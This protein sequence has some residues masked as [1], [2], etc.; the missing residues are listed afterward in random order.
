M[1]Y[2]RINGPLLE[3]IRNWLTQRTQKV[4]LNGEASK[5]VKVISGV[6]QGTV[7]GLLMFLLYVNDI[8]DNTS[9]SIRMFADDCV[10]YRI[11]QTPSDHHYLQNDL[12]A[13]I[14]WA[15]KWQM[16]LNVNK[17]VVLHCTRSQSPHLSDYY[18]DSKPLPTQEQ[19]QYL[20]LTIHQSLSWSNHIHN[21]T[22]KAS[23]TLNFIRRNLSKCS[24]EVKE[25][26]YLT[27]VRP[28]L[29]YAACVWDPYQLYLKKEIEKIQRRAARWTLSD[30]SRY[31]SV[32]KMLS[33]LQWAT[34][35]QRR[36]ITR[37]SILFYKIL[38]DHDFPVQ[39]SPYFLTT[40]YPTK[41]YHPNHFILPPGNTTQYQLSY[42]P[43]TIKDWN[44]LPLSTIESPSLTTFVCSLK[45]LLDWLL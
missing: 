28:C 12:D 19:H 33:Q 22:S 31:N 38:Y 43:R 21:I 45:T 17:S 27:L 36:Y 16:N 5:E 8:Y 14:L 32:S 6:P 25:S 11:I 34:L 13:I 23:R 26:A 10:L 4:V 9:S 42:F 3:W 20:G 2:Y 7:L 40:Q 18:M 24:I 35:E 41:Q 37:L 1:S 15:N 30:Y 44:T 29:E 39:I